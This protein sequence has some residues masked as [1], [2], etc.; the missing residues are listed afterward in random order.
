MK[1][2]KAVGDEDVVM[3]RGKKWR[4]GFLLDHGGGERRAP[5]E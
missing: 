3:N 1:G 2:K 5:G 4:L